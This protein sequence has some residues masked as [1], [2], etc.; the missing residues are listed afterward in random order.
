MIAVLL[1]MAARGGE[2]D[3]PDESDPAKRATTAGTI[4]VAVGSA[5]VVGGVALLMVGRGD[6]GAIS[7]ESNAWHDTRT[8]GGSVLI[9]AGATTIAIG[10]DSLSR[11]A[12]LRENQTS[13]ARAR[14]SP[15]L[16]PRGAG[17]A[18]HLT[19]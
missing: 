14:L 7:E 15:L 10:I 19:F 12:R 1:L 11:G 6:A 13:Q 8:I 3:P 16:V 4:E 18:L 9:L 17:V 2:G 5:A